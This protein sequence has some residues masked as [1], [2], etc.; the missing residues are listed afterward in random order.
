MSAPGE[1]VPHGSTT[2]ETIEDWAARLRSVVPPLER[3]LRSQSPDNVTPTQLSVFGAIYRHGP[4]A[5]GELAH[6]ER[7]SPPTIS[8][9]VSS[10][11]DRGL[12]ERLRDAEDRRVCR[13]VVSQTGHEFIHEGRA[14]RNAWLAARIEALS[15]RE[16]SALVA[17]IPVLE[18]LVERDL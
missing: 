5:L 6:R 15:E 10:L 17:A 3:S 1:S 9:V 18:R 16:R 14:R 7:L 13:V 11:E 4:L 2:D 8:K 12:I